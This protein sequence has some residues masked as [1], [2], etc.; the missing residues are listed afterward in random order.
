MMGP[1]GFG[2]EGGGLDGRQTYAAVLAICPNRP[3][4]PDEVGAAA[5]GAAGGGA[6]VV[7][8]A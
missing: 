8:A 6:W 1:A 2:R 7:G 5:A 3:E 4:P